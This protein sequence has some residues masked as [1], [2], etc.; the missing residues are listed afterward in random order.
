MR[1]HENIVQDSGSVVLINHQSALDILG[2]V[3]ILSILMLRYNILVDLFHYAK[4]LLKNSAK[5]F[6]CH[7]HHCQCL[8]VPVELAVMVFAFLFILV[9][10]AELLV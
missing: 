2:N 8:V 1:G 6:C 10:V 9:G 5:V 4:S 3:Y 7:V